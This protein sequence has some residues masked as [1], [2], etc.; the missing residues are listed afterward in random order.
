[1]SSNEFTFAWEGA[2]TDIASWE[3]LRVASFEG[4]EALG[5]L[6]ARPS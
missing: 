1:M 4:R 5:A 6:A 2:C 3:H